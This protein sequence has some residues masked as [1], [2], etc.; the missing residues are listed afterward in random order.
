MRMTRR[1]CQN[2][3]LSAWAKG[4]IISVT[5][6]LTACRPHFVDARAFARV[7]E[8]ANCNGQPEE[9]EAPL[10]GV[11]VW[12]GDHADSPIP[13][14]EYCD[15]EWGQTD[16]RGLWDSGL[17]WNRSCTDVYIFVRTPDGFQPTTGIVV[18]GCS[19][20]FGFARSLACPK[21]AIRTPADLVAH[22]RKMQVF[23]NLAW[24]LVG[25]IVIALLGGLFL[26]E[27]RKKITP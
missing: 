19:A 10:Q 21:R 6:L 4:I 11:C 13:H 22:E 26:L 24:V 2:H 12:F 15:N 14:S 17:L 7:W 3:R 5:L 27:R 25:S 16:S 8:D 1:H 18:N 23:T 20:E 9:G